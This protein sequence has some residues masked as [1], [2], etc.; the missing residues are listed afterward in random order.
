MKR[1][2]AILFLMGVLPMLSFAQQPAQYSLYMLN[3][4]HWN[5]AYAGLDNSLS[6]TGGLRR[7]WV[8]LDG[9]PASQFANAHA[10][11]YFLSGGV[12]IGIENE[13]LG[14]ETLTTASLS[15]SYQR[16]IGKGIL[17][18]GLGAAWV[19]RTIDGALLRTPDGNYSEPGV[20]NHEDDLLP[21]GLETASTPTFNAGIYYQTEKWEGGIGVRHL[22][23]PATPLGQLQL[24]LNRVYFFTVSAHLDLN[25]TL[26]IHPS[27]MIHS[28]AVQTQGQIGVIVKYNNNIFAGTALRGYNKNAIDAAIIMAGLQLNEKISLAY[29]YDLT[30]SGLDAV[31]NGS[32]ELVLKYN[33]GKIIG[34]GKLPRIIYN[35]RSN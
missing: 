30:L 29:A 27:L 11:L 8:G 26:S 1:R 16:Q 31:S 9:S 20:I 15:Y 21:L 22:T 33:L 23:A 12:G 19:Q 5:P 7:Q 32:H 28:D 3:P 18:L 10:P 2:Y 14:A 25:K 34:A 4:L 35:P 6:I 13:S 17:A 24:Q